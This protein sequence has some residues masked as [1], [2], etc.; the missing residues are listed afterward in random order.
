MKKPKQPLAI[1]G[2]A[3][4]RLA[5]DLLIGLRAIADYLGMTVSA[6]DHMIRD[7]NLPTFLRG[8]R[9]FARRS[10]LEAH[11]RSAPEQREHAEK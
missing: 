10:E 3:G 8:R 5:D 6:V 7:E 4:P 1:N 9:R 2:A 11:L